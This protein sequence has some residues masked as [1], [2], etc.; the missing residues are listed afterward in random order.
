MADNNNGSQRDAAFSN[1]FGAAPPGRFNGSRGPGASIDAKHNNNNNINSNSSSSN[2]PPPLPPSVSSHPPQ[3]PPIDTGMRPMRAELY[4]Q[5]SGKQPQ[6]SPPQ[7]PPLGQQRP[8][9]QAA[10]Y[11]PLHPP[12]APHGAYNGTSESPPVSPYSQAPQA[13]RSPTSPSST[14]PPSGPRPLPQGMMQQRPRQPPQPQPQQQQQQ[15]FNGG[16]FNGYYGANN[17]TTT[18]SNGSPQA[19]YPLYQGQFPSPSLQQAN[20]RRPPALLQPPPLRPQ[21]R[22]SPPSSNDGS[23][24]GSPV[25]V[26]D[27]QAAYLPQ[28]QTPPQ[29]VMMHHQSPPRQT[30]PPPAPQQQPMYQPQPQPQPQ[31][32]RSVSSPMHKQPAPPG[33]AGSPALGGGNQ[34]TMVNNNN[35]LGN[36]NSTASLTTTMSRAA[37]RAAL[38]EQR[39]MSMTSAS[40]YQQQ[41]PI[42]SAQTARASGTPFDREHRSHTMT[43]S[44]R[45][46]P[47][48]SSDVFQKSSLLGNLKGKNTRS[49]STSE[50][51]TGHTVTPSVS[52]STNVSI[53]GG[54]ERPHLSP[55]STILTTSRRVPLVYP[56]L[57]SKV[58]ETFR[59]RIVLG[60]RIKNELTYKNSFTGA[61]AVELIT[62]IIKTPDRNLALLLGRALD[63]QKFFHDVT[64]D[65]RLRD[66][67]SEVYQFN[68]IVVEDEGIDE[69]TKAKTTV[70]VNGVFT[71]LAECYSP[72]C[73]RD[74]LCYSI[75]C[76]RRLEQQA[77][78]NMKPQP[79]LK[80]AESRLSLHG[81]DE[82]EQKLWIHTVSKEVA[83]S[84]SDSE[85][86][87][88]EVICEVIYT[89]RDFVKDLEYLRDFWIKPLRNSNIVPVGRKEKFI[90]DVFSRIME[91]HSVN[92]K[93]AEALTKRQQQAPVVKQIG[94]IFLEHVPKFEPF[95]RYGGGQLM[96]KYEFERE[97]SQNSTFAKFVDETERLKESRKLE[98]NGYLTKPTT[99]LA[100]Y[101]LLL[102]A[103]LKNTEDDNPDKKNLPEAIKLIRQF[104]TRVNE[105]TGKAEN[106]FNLIT[107][108]QQLIW[109]SQHDYVDMRLTDDRRQIIFKSTLKKRTQDKDNQGDVQVYLF[110]HCL[111]FV[112][113]K[114]VNKRDQLKVHRK[115]IPLNL[116]MMSESE[117]IPSKGLAKRPTGSSLLPGGSGGG[118]NNRFPITFQYLGRKGYDLTLYATTFI[119]RKKWTEHIEQQKQ[120]LAQKGD[121][122]TAH[123]LQDKFFTNQNRVNCLVPLD[124]GRKLL[125]GTDNGI[126]ISDVKRSGTNGAT[127]ATT[128][129]KV[130]TLANVTQLDV[131]EEY[132]TLLALS[133]KSL[134]S[135]PLDCLDT[136]DPVA[137]SR[138]SKKVMGHINFYKVGI[139]LG[140]VLVCTVKSS[141]L[142]TTVK[143]MEPFDPQPRGRRQQ[144]F[145]KL[146]KN[147]NEGLKMFK[148]F[149]IPSEALSIS[150]LKRKLCVGC[151]KGFEIVDLKTL[152]TQSLLD[153]ADTSLDFII[154][155][156]VLKPIAIYP[157]GRNF[158]LNYSDVSFF[159]NC[160]GWRA[161]PE[162]K[163]EWEGVPSHFAF[164]YPYLIAFEPNFI[165][166]RLVDTGELIRVITG[167]NIRFLHEST[168]EILYV[169]EDANGYDEVVSLDFWEKQEEQLKQ[170]ERK[171][172]EQANHIDDVTTRT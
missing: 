75:A 127:I 24:Y 116:L 68:E 44:G 110:D 100:R 155:R 143:V 128:P 125:Y 151:A 30:P 19:A 152:E 52:S 63:A 55:H 86:K 123:V 97:K 168:R 48:R 134:Y 107:L 22:Q 111:L 172:E 34:S 103:V 158:L 139:C 23:A 38:T 124:G 72:T 5:P 1:I 16:Q 148:E 102:E 161:I 13:R 114:H 18:S 95:I 7:Q 20:G 130:I 160:N 39:S 41:H 105:E 117:E 109:R 69:N 83:D 156:D 165:E 171:K 70:P 57:L 108:N 37:E 144:P 106:R 10:G 167:E 78:L 80:R 43:L 147:Q 141:S 50:R 164:T 53:G 170:Q 94:D 77:R 133:D 9:R 82:K 81:D 85:K 32:P 79:G 140:R 46:I 21:S 96:G 61:E 145:S 74:K 26:S 137:N 40:T 49:S 135:W 47:Q 122:F 28:S 62:Y 101:P 45:V 121:V 33:V 29:N 17:N 112:R 65:H 42:G 14:M 132:T 89:E 35:P 149:Y 87:R 104:L 66:T 4:E 36:K 146:L 71:L 6:Y 67:N 162:W 120:M 131:L 126:W 142:T 136:P 91:V 90:R 157:L 129:L 8:L 60:D 3:L 118:N 88:Q 159:V 115:P 119:G 25:S 150:F 76:P 98:L 11:S 2:T 154:R 153:P 12:Q 54:G 92:V 163:I 58:A 93:L 99:R 51:S 56:A 27:H 169:H 166:I 138:R 31:P 15:Q 64:Y 113:V 73:T 84:V 59:E